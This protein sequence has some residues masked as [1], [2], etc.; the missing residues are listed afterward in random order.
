MASRP[1]EAMALIGLGY[2]SISMAPASVGPVK[3]MIL[4]LDAGELQRW[5]RTTLAAAEGNVR[6]QLKRYAE[7]HGVEI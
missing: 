2:R 5:L 1:I 7:E 6:P 3:S 4:S